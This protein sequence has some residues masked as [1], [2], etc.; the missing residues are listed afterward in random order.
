MSI[1]LEL[2]VYLNV[3]KKKRVLIN[4]N[5]YRNAHYQVSNKVKGEYHKLITAKLGQI[6]EKITKGYEIHYRYYYK[7][8]V[9]DL[10]NVTS[11]IDK[12]LND[13]LQELGIVENDNVKYLRKIVCEVGGQ[14]KENPRLEIEIREI[15]NGN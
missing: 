3:T 15:E 11:V 5:W 8:V 13:S 4:M 1:R 9:S 6:K 12:F 14:D 2:P 7:S 10:T